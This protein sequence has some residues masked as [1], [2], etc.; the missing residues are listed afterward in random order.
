MKFA[1]AALV[2][3]LSSVT[4][5]S[6]PSYHK[7]EIAIKGIST[8]HS[9]TLACGVA[10]EEALKEAYNRDENSTRSECESDVAYSTCQCQGLKTGQFTCTYT[11]AVICV[12]EVWYP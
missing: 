11:G 10:K 4:L 3:S 12:E 7:T 9:D 2:L 5:A 1:I 8:R 6:G